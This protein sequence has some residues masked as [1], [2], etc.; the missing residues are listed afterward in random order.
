MLLKV[1]PKTRMAERIRGERL[2]IFNVT[3]RDLQDILF[4]TLDRLLYDE[5]LL[6]I[7]QSRRWQEN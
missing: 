2:R 1:D 4:C 3:E 5:E 7:M 6:I